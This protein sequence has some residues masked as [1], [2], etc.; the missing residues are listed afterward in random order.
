MTK[1]ILNLRELLGRPAPPPFAA[2]VRIHTF[3][4]MLADAPHPLGKPC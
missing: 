1:H 2:R 3:Q 4:R